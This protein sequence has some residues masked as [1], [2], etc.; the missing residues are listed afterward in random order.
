MLTG[1]FTDGSFIKHL[2]DEVST[3]EIAFY[4]SRLRQHESNQN[5]ATCTNTCSIVEN[6]SSLRNYLELLNSSESTHVVPLHL[7]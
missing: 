2:S 1:I 7:R 4:R 3:K 6:N 5:Q